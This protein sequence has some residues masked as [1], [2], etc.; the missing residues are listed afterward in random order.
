ME[1]VGEYR[2]DY[3]DGQMLAMLFN[4]IQSIYGK[5]EK[6]RTADIEDFIPWMEKKTKPIKEEA[7]Q[8]PEEI[9]EL[10]MALKG[11]QKKG[12]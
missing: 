5:K 1:P 12:R 6:R 2:R 3:M 4:T 11:K 8:S 10:F 9:K 7:T